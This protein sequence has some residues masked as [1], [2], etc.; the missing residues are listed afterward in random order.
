MLRTGLASRQRAFHS[1]R[2]SY[3]GISRNASAPPHNTHKALL[4]LE[5][6]T[7]FYGCR[8]VVRP[9]R[10]CANPLFGQSFELVGPRGVFSSSIVS[11]DFGLVARDRETIHG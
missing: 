2:G 1:V 7:V 11:F 8:G 4:N 5:N 3:K 10:L 9:V 6:G